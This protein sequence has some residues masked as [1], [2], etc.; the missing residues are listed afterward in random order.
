MKRYDILTL[1]LNNIPTVIGVGAIAPTT[2]KNGSYA[3]AYS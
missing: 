1:L 3:F 2:K